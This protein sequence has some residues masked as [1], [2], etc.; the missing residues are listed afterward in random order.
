MPV[1]LPER[2]EEVEEPEDKDSAPSEAVDIVASSPSVSLPEPSDIAAEPSIS[3]VA[4]SDHGST[5]ATTPVSTAPAKL[6]QV[7]MAKPSNRPQP[8]VPV[9][10]MIPS[11]GKAKKSSSTAAMDLEKPADAVIPVESDIASVSNEQTTVAGSDAGSSITDERQRPAVTPA[12]Q[13]P[14]SW[15]DLVRSQA[16]PPAQSDASQAPSTANSTTLPYGANESLADVLSS[17]EIPQANGTSKIA[18]LKPR[19]LINTGNMCYMNSV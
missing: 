5:D 12:R 18:F 11:L 1:E 7:P 17:F 15:A 10:P 4:V 3:S 9:V 2:E 14:K 8:I 19:G 6:A 13:A 16:L